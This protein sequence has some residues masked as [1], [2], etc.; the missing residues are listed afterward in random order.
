MNSQYAAVWR[1]LLVVAAIGGW[2]VVS[3]CASTDTE[4]E[5]ERPWNSPHMWEH[6]LPPEMMQGR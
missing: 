5:S 3:G 2:L 4:N 6:G 1:W